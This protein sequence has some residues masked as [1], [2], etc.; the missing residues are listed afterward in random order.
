MTCG[1]N[2]RHDAWLK[3]VHETCDEAIRPG[4][5]QK[6]QIAY[7]QTIR[8]NPIF[9]GNRVLFWLSHYRWQVPRQKQLLL[10]Q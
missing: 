9:G 6:V 8:R 7:L 5:M 4:G 10:A 1:R 3:V 2:Q